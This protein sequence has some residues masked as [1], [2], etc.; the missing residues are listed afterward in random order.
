[1][2]TG[3]DPDCQ[4]PTRFL[5][6]HLHDHWHFLPGLLHWLHVADLSGFGGRGPQSP[7]PGGWRIIPGLALIFLTGS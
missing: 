5:R 4:F 1:M 7:P 2:I 6:F 3:L